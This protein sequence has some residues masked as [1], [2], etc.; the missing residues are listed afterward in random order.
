MSDASDDLARRIR[1]TLGLRP[2]LSETRMMG[3]VCFMLSGHMVAGPL[4]DGRLLVRVGKENYEAALTRPGAGPMTFT[5]RPMSGFVEVAPD[6]IEDDAVLSDWLALAE[7]FVRT[8]PPKEA[9]V[10]KPRA[11]K[12]PATH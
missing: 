3:G 10:R 9:K 8:L 2:D 7:S 12:A 1:A 6:D 5:G 4:K 11:R